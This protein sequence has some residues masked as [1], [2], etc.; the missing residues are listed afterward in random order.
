MKV[1]DLTMKPK[2]SNAFHIY[3]DDLTMEVDLPMKP[4]FGN[5]FHIYCDDLIMKFDD[6]TNET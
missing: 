5:S 2:F 1:D 4:E 6:L 3:C